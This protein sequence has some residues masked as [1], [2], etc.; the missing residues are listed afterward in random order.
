MRRIH[1]L[2][3]AAAL[4]LAATVA[5]A[6]WERDLAEAIASKDS[7]KRHAAVRALDPSDDKALKVLLQ[8][9]EKDD[10]YAREAAI[11]ALA[12]AKGEALET[13]QKKMKRGDGF[14]Q[15]GIALAFAASNDRARVPDILPL[16]KEKDP[17]SRWAAAVALSKL[18]ETQSIPALL[19]AWEEEKEARLRFRYYETLKAITGEDI[20]Q[21]LVDWRNWFKGV[22]DEFV[23]PSQR[24]KEQGAGEGG[25]QKKEE[26][27]TVLRDVELSFTES[28]AGGPLF[29]LPEYGYNKDYLVPAMKELEDVCR[30]FYI[31][32]PS[33]DKFKNLSMA[34]GTGIPYYP[35]D[36]LVDAFDELRIQRKQKTI[37]ILGHGITAWVAMRYATKYPQNVSHLILVSTWSGGSA[38]ERGR[39]RLEQDGKDKGD[40][41]Q[42][43][44]AQSLLIDMQTGQPTYQAKDQAEAEALFRMGWTSYFADRREGMAL[45]LHPEV[46]RAMGQCIV[47]DFEI[48]KEKGNPVPTLIIYGKQAVWTDYND[49]RTMAKCYPNSALIACPSSNMLPMIEDYKT[50]TKALEGFFRKY[51]FRGR[52]GG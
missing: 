31:D 37:A 32:L 44:Y 30:I 33:L 24:E 20:G 5:Y 38:F 25:T 7:N 28:G 4:A 26:S 42:E 48:S 51:K 40:I 21:T 11:S 34:G 18:H 45:M 29:V 16:L 14:L 46:H 36:K 41:E 52:L 19:D 9:V 39:A 35:I 15:E 1:T 8:I 22:G 27:G 23:P 43:H 3:G 13:L 10:W 12:G 17:R 2:T 47:P 49:M 6:G 50:F